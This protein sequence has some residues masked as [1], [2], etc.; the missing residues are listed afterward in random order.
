MIVPM[1]DAFAQL[2]APYIGV[3]YASCM[4]IIRNGE[5]MIMNVEFNARWGDPEA[6]L[7]LPGIKNDWFEVGMHLAEGGSLK[8]LKIKRDNLRRVVVAI[9]ANGYPGDYSR[10]MGKKI[11]GIYNAAA[12]PG[13]SLYG[14]GM[15]DDG[16]DYRVAGGR[17]IHVM[18]EGKTLQSARKNAYAGVHEISIEGDNQVFR[19]DI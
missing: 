10:V 17:V 1:L 4:K 6:Q 18:G 12:K 19:S 2:K 5:P 9:A 11:T 3:L 15:M 7:V 8:G 14:A 13:V 16:K